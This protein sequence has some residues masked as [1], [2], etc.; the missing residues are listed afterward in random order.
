VTGALR[1]TGLVD[2]VW[3]DVAPALSFES[4][5]GVAAFTGVMTAGSNIVSN[6]PMV[7]LT[8]PYL[9]TLGDAQLGHTLLAYIT[10]IAGNLTLVGSVANL[11]VAEGARA[12]YDLGFVEYL[13]FGA[14]STLLTLAIG[15]RPCSASGRRSFSEPQRPRQP[16][17]RATHTRRSAREAGPRCALRSPRPGS[18]RPPSCVSTRTTHAIEVRDVAAVG[19]HEVWVLGAGILSTRTLEAQ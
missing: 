6:V 13:R 19:A 18:R 1:A 15:V 16:R 11:I 12:H 14:L 2:A 5:S 10:T 8:G 4:T 17:P 7:V 3:Q 9:H